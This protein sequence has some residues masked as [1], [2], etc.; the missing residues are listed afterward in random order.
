MRSSSDV[1][2]GRLR[3]KIA[4]GHSQSQWGCAARKV[5]SICVVSRAPAGHN[6][7]GQPMAIFDF[8][9]AN[10]ATAG[11]SSATRSPAVR[12]LLESAWLLGFAAISTA[13]ERAT[14]SA[15]DKTLPDRTSSNT[16]VSTVGPPSRATLAP[17]ATCF[18]AEIPSRAGIDDD[19][20]RAAATAW[21]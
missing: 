16:G 19:S 17:E 1:P 15:T 20:D 6:K 12:P 4:D 13:D 18:S 5:P 2:A 21:R 14:R 10:A 9:S 11:G 7:L 3:K 8:R